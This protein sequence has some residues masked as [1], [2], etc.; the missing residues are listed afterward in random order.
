MT[1]LTKNRATNVIN[2]ADYN[3][4]AKKEIIPKIHAVI[5]RKS[6]KIDFD[7]FDQEM[8]FNDEKTKELIRT[9]NT[10]GCFYIESPGMRSLLKKL[11]CDTFEMLTAASSIIR[12]GVAESGMMQEFI[13]RHKNPNRRKYL[14]PEMEKHLRETYGIMIYQEDVLKIAHHVVGF[15]LEEADLLRRAMSGKMRS[16]SEMKKLSDK[17]FVLCKKKNYSHNVSMALWKQIESFA[18]YAFNK[19]HSASFAILSFQVAY[20]KV[21]FPAQF[22]ANVLNNRGGYYSAA[23]YIQESKR[24]G[25][26]ILLP[27]INKSKYEYVG[28]NGEIRIGFMAIKSLMRNS[29]EQVIEE[30]NKNGQFS[31]LSNLIYRTNLS[32]KEAALLITIG[33][34]RCF[35]K[36]RPTLMRLLDIYIVSQ[37]IMVGDLFQHEA[38]KLEGEV[39]TD[40]EYTIEKICAIELETFGYMISRH[41]LQFFSYLTNNQN[42]ISAK[43]I[44]KHRG[45][46]VRM[47]GW[48][49]T[50]KRIK[51]KKG[52][53][54]KFLSLEDLT[55]TF[56][57]IL[58]PKVYAQFAEKTLSMGPY[59]VK[60]RIDDEDGDNIIVSNLAIIS[61]KLISAI[62]QKDSAETQYTGDKEKVY[63]EEFMIIDSLGKEKLRRAYAS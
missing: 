5:P 55:G 54:M 2:M 19:A 24:M 10:I 50:S 29:I 3:L 22:M 44:P 6:G 34:M 36:T 56:E 62:A 31:S 7:I 42:V 35:E 17:F 37:K 1:E 49:M 58:F 26:R 16:H 23:V 13:A 38:Y 40:V 45:K 60:G 28:K 12:P 33:A 20:L 25:L 32:Y 46:I 52:K 9:G 4:S 39:A 51:T 41:P 27:N 57:A 14:I 53:I 59:F 30:R 11:K 21:H 15:S 8:I 48:F 43:E 63:E 61:D 47:V 18:G